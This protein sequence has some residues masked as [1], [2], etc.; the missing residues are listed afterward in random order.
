M[1]LAS[2]W[3]A[4][5]AQSAIPVSLAKFHGDEYNTEKQSQ[6]GTTAIVTEVA[7]DRATVVSP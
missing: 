3:Y 5:S 1:P 2:I 6:S 7:Q 4:Y